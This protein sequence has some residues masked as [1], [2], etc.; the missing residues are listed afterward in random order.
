M[1]ADRPKREPSQYEL[2]E[3]RALSDP[4]GT[5]AEALEECRI[6]YLNGD[7]GRLAIAIRLCAVTGW[8]LPTWAADAWI[9]ACDAVAYRTVASWD[10]VLV[11]NIK[12]VPRTAKKLARQHRE[13]QLKNKI[14]DLLPS[15][16]ELP[17]DDVF[18]ETIGKR[19]AITSRQSKALYYKLPKTALLAAITYRPP[20]PKRVPKK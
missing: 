15:L 17:I 4:L 20:P 7:K 6:Q 11:S 8:P 1:G 14:I 2:T 19:L 18:F 12:R 16:R 13:R 3:Q 5:A 9:K 10:D